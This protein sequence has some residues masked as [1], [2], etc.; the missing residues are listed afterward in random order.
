MSDLYSRTRSRHSNTASGGIHDSGS[1]PAASSSR[2]SLASLQVFSE[3]VASGALSVG[4]EL[5]WPV[6]GGVVDGAGDQCGVGRVQACY[7]VVEVDGDSFGETGSDPQQLA[8]AARAWE[9]AGV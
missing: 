3:L 1:S 6:T 2:S 9:P 8:F 5:S 4:F 7:R